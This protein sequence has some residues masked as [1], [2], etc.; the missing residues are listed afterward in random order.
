MKVYLV[1]AGEWETD[2]RYV[3]S[4]EDLAKQMCYEI[5]KE[6]GIENEDYSD[7]IDYTEYEVLGKTKATVRFL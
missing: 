5:A 6:Y 1:R 4:D 2:V 3:C 7:C